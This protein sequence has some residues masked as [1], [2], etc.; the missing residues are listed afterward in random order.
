MLRLLPIRHNLCRPATLCH[1]VVETKT[2]ELCSKKVSAAG[3]CLGR[4]SKRGL[5]GWLQ[6]WRKLRCGV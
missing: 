5:A 6:A 2:I 3:S 1:I 4:I